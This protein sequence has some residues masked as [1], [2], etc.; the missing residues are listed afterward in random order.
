MKVSQ[1]L[2]TSL[3]DTGR[4]FI[5]PLFLECYKLQRA[6]TADQASSNLKK[7]ALL[8][9]ASTNH[10]VFFKGFHVQAVF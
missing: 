9:A 1:Q 3:F 5:F 4:Y 6:P 7:V 10:K 2:V 8:S